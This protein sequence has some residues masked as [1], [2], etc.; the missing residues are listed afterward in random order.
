MVTRLPVHSWPPQGSSSETR[1]PIQS[2]S[3]GCTTRPP[4]P[5]FLLPIHT[6]YRQRWNRDM[7]MKTRRTA[8]LLAMSTWPEAALARSRFIG[9]TT[10][11]FQ[12]TTIRFFRT[13]T[14]PTLR[15]VGRGEES[16]R[17]YILVSFY[18]FNMRREVLMMMILAV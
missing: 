8:T 9:C 17:G 4:P 12:I 13:S 11:R 6:C 1:C 18:K 16:W 5:I 7:P 2:L 10:T 14:T 3:F 15:M